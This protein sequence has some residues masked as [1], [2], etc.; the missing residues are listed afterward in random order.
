MRARAHRHKSPTSRAVAR[1]AA[2][3]PRD[4][5]AAP[6]LRPL[7]AVGL[8]R[9]RRPLGDIGVNC[10]ACRPLTGGALLLDGSGPP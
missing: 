1:L 10:A 9:D 3:P 5:A 2:V 4:A 7:V 8:E 6:G